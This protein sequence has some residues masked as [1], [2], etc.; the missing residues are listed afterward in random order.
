LREHV[1]TGFDLDVPFD[2]VLQRTDVAGIQG[3]K[4]LTD[5]LFG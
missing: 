4:R 2:E 5:D 1:Q 3:K